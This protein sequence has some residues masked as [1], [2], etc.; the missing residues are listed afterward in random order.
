MRSKIVGLLL[1][2]ALGGV[3]AQGAEPA[4]Q[5]VQLR[6]V[7]LHEPI[8]G[9]GL[10]ETEG[11]ATPLTI[12]SD[13]LSP[14]VAHPTGRLRLV[15]TQVAPRPTKAAGPI[16][17]EDIPPQTPGFRKKRIVETTSKVK[18][19]TRELGWIDLPTGDHQRYIILVHPGKG[20]GLTA[21]P[22]RLGSFPPSSDRYVNLTTASVIIDIP[23]GRQTLAPNGSIVL[24]P[25]AAHLRQYQL[26]LLTKTDSEEKLLFSAF[27]AQDDGRRNL[28]LLIP[29]P[30]DPSSLLMKTISDAQANEDNYR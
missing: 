26:R 11:R 20:S 4:P 3:T 29:D 21:I 17:P 7:S 19:G 13:S 10:A 6:F 15:S 12:P 27:T 1:L 2:A 9:A 23:A 16:R 28:R 24:R 18:A 30:A 14:P 25:G 22:D 5:R 8:F